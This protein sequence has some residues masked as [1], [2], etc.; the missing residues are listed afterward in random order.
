[1]TEDKSCHVALRTHV[2]EIRPA[3]VIRMF[4]HDFNKVCQD[5]KISLEDKRF[6]KI[7]ENG[8]QRCADGHF[9]LPFPLRDEYFVL[10]NNKEAVYQRLMGLKVYS[11]ILKVLFLSF[12]S[13][14]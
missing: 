7:M 5:E 1:M 4:D 3:A 2:A 10:P 13:Q 8:I 9:V 11:P 6:L 14:R 12:I